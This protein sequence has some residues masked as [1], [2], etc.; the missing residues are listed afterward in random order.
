MEIVLIYTLALVASVLIVW[1]CVGGLLVLGQIEQGTVPEGPVLE[2]CAAEMQQDYQSAADS[3]SFDATGQTSYQFVQWSQQR[4]QRL[5]TVQR[6]DITGRNYIRSFVDPYEADY[7]MHVTFAGGTTSQ[8][9]I[10]VHRYAPDNGK[11]YWAIFHLDPELN[12]SPSGLAVVTPLS[13]QA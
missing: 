11:P 7:F 10:G 4:D 12:L 2:F 13:S 8:G 6:C 3:L 9:T 5:G 1:G